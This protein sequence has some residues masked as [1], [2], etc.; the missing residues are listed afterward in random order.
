MGAQVVAVAGNLEKGDA[1]RARRQGPVQYQDGSFDA[2]VGLEHAGGQRHY[3]HQIVRHQQPAQLRVPAL[4]LE[5]DALRHDDAGPSAG[6]KM[7]GD[8][9]HKQ[10]FAAAGWHR[11]A[12]VGPDAAFGGHKGRVGHNHI[13]K[14]LPAFLTGQ[15][16]VF[17]DLRVGKP[18]QIHIDQRQSH[19]IRRQVI[20]VQV[21]GQPSPFVGR[22]GN[23]AVGVGIGGQNMLVGRD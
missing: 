8:I 14:V 10:H 23:G 22:Q 6:R 9:V 11:K 7:F 21:A 20:A 2:A 3:G 4:A 18:V 15:S 17:I 16:V 1:V 13:G 12:V 19:Q 5:N